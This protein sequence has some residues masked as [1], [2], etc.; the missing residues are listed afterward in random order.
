MPLQE[1][2]EEGKSKLEKNILNLKR[3]YTEALEER[4]TIKSKQK[5]MRFHRRQL[6]KEF[7]S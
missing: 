6:A 4:K 1:R 5:S 2:H 3:N 7:G